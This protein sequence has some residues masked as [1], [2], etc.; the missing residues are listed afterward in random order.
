MALTQGEVMQVFG[1]AMIKVGEEFD[2]ADK[3]NKDE[4]VGVVTIAFTDL[5]KEYTD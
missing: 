4:L 5:L 2:S 1:K 3:I